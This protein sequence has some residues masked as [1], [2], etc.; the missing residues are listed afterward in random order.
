MKL[1]AIDYNSFSIAYSIFDQ[2]DW[3]FSGLFKNEEVVPLL[4]EYLTMLDKFAITDAVIEHLFIGPNANS[5]VKLA[6]VHGAIQYET[7]RRG[8]NYHEIYPAHWKGKFGLM[9]GAVKN[10]SLQ[11]RR[12]IEYAQTLM[13]QERAVDGFEFSKAG[14]LSTV[15]DQSNVADSYLIGVCWLQEVGLR[16]T[17]EE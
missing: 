9:K 17:I 4:D 16:G 11:K 14:G 12:S 1:V 13:E 8:V 3:Y 6:L 2:G 15:V 10:R 7:L 5:V